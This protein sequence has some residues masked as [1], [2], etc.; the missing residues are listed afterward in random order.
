MSAALTDAWL[1]MRERF[2]GRADMS[3][4]GTFE[5]CRSSVTVP[6]FGGKTG[7]HRRRAKPTRLTVRPEGANYQ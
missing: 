4:N 6:A 1:R 2:E 3:L 7:S 5:T